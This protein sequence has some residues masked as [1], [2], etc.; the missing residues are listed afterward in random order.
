M[1]CYSGQKD[2]TPCSSLLGRNTTQAECCCT[3]GTGWGDACDLCPDEDSGKAPKGPRSSQR[4]LGR[5]TQKE[6]GG[7]GAVGVQSL[8]LSELG[9][10]PA[11]LSSA[12]SALVG[13]ATSLLKE[14]GCL[15]RPH[16]QVTSP[17]PSSPNATHLSGPGLVPQEAS[18]CRL[19]LSG[20]F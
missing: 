13:K 11:Q 18:A 3:Q 16:T 1:E 4:R 15:D 7:E 5:V 8:S 2:Q 14:P 6:V 20:C 12:R 17:R 19:R 9:C 10:L